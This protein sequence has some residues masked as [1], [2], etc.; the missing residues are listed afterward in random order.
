MG[1]C[2]RRNKTNLGFVDLLQAQFKSTS[3]A[4]YGKIP[5][6]W[7]PYNLVLDRKI[8]SESLCPV[9]K[10]N[11][12]I[13]RRKSFG[14]IKCQSSHLSDTDVQ[15]FKSKTVKQSYKLDELSLSSHLV[16]N[17]NIK[18]TASDIEQYL[19]KLFRQQSDLKKLRLT[20]GSYCLI[21]SDKLLKRIA[22]EMTKNLT[23]LT[24][25]EVNLNWYRNI[26]G[27]GLRVLFSRMNQYLTDLRR[28]E[29][30]FSDNFNNDGLEALGGNLHR[31]LSKLTHFKLT[32]YKGSITDDG[33]E[34]FIQ[35][36]STECK[37]LQ[38]L[39]LKFIFVENLTD[40]GVESLVSNI[41]SNLPTL[42][43]LS[44]S[45][46]GCGKTTENAFKTTFTKIGQEMGSLK[47]LSLAF[48]CSKYINDESF[49]IFES[50]NMEHLANLKHLELSFDLCP[51]LSE[52]T[53]ILLS[54]WIK[55][56]LHNLNKLNLDFKRCHLINKKHREKAL[57]ELK[58]ISELKIQ[59]EC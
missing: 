37:D 25:L 44:L 58:Y 47:E 16:D 35:K 51:K 9:I 42:Q 56:N 6:G 2:Q 33:L 45:F 26:T 31:N 20:F 41:S 48:H 14:K 28:L 29:L 27:D 18:I 7:Q 12:Q 36:L 46:I 8:E 30:S 57:K 53:L 15:E 50:T 13:H 21:I 54:K 17:S 19:S 10:R 52:T 55:A 43:H 59:T 11:Y 40:R 4:I 49:Q 24:H 38:Q 5:L 23:N 32:T 39:S 22:L 34:L 1:N 3:P